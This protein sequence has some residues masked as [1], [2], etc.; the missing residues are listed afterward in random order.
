MHMDKVD[1]T[2]HISSQLNEALEHVRGRVLRMG[3]VVEQQIA[4]AMRALT[5]TDVMLAEE[6]AGN[7][8]QV[9]SL[10]VSLDEEC[11]QIL[12]RRQ[13]AAGDLRLVVAIIK[14]I[15]D[16]ERIGDE[17]EKIARTAIA[18]TDRRPAPNYASLESLANHVRG[19]L[20]DALDAFARLDAE[21]ALAVAREDTRVD[22][23]YEM[24]MRQ[25]ITYMMEDQRTIRG[26]IDLMWCARALERIGDHASN[27][28]EYVIYLVQGKD[29]RH[30]TLDEMAQVVRAERA[31]NTAAA[32]Q[33]DADTP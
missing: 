23:E 10:E 21:A 18:T 12:A 5:E 6:V 11:T 19:M 13:P 1:V 17:A 30:T 26:M 33:D 8:Y 16:L 2:H 32:P 4:R 24:L 29:V 14:T 22:H 20:R 27:I 3:G 9:N 31:G 28:C 15:T 25:C 7:D